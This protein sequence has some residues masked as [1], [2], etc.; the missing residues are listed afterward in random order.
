MHRHER[1]NTIKITA[2]CTDPDT[3]ALVDPDT[4]SCIVE[5]PDGVEHHTGAMSQVGTGTYRAE[6]EIGFTADIGH[7]LV[8]IYGT[9]DSKQVA[10]AEKIRVVEVV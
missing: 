10:N 5:R 2:V 9:Y 6:V 1:G 4:V 3:G 8:K 7:W